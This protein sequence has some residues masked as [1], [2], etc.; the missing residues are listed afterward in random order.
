VLPCHCEYALNCSRILAVDAH[1]QTDWILHCFVRYYA[2][3]A[4]YEKEGM[5][6]NDTEALK[7][8]SND[9]YS[10]SDEADISII[11]TDAGYDARVT[12]SLHTA[13]INQE[14][15]LVVSSSLLDTSIIGIATD[16]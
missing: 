7:Q 16:L 14:R 9:K 3:K 5:Y 12:L 13:T 1:R 4:H 10:I 2:L 8:Y 11:L 6:T 15:Y